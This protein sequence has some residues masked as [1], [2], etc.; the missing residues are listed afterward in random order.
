M[1]FN[2]KKLKKYLKSNLKDSNNELILF[3][4]CITN[5]ILKINNKL[6][7]PNSIKSNI[8]IYFL[9]ISIIN[10]PKEER[11]IIMQKY[12][13]DILF[14]SLIS[15]F[16]Y[17]ENNS[18]IINGEFDIKLLASTLIS[19]K[20][21]YF[22]YFSNSLNINEPFSNSFKYKMI[23]NGFIPLNILEYL[24]SCFNLDGGYGSNPGNESHCGYIYAAICSYKIL[25]DFFNIKII[26]SCINKKQLIKFY[27]SLNANLGI[28]G[29]KNKQPDL[30]YNFWVKATLKI[31]KELKLIKIEINNLFPNLNK[32]NKLCYKKNG[33]ASHWLFEEDLFHTIYFILSEYLDLELNPIFLI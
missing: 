6:N 20:I 31:L 2:E 21:L 23:E 26:Q 19:L 14:N 15:I 9:L 27:K 16:K 4:K 5:N 12:N 29:R 30:C 24:N 7:F 3:F 8:L 33:F 28:K 18:E 17:K 32:F 13:K 22:L 11:I 25:I 10:L 1:I